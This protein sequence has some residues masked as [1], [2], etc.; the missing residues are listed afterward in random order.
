MAILLLRE[1]FFKSK[2]GL[3]GF[4]HIASIFYTALILNISSV[5]FFYYFPYFQYYF[6]LFLN[7]VLLSCLCY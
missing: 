3:W 2:L 4:L 1:T 7:L 6:G 5:F